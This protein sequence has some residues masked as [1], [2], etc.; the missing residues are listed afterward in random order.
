MAVTIDIGDPDDIHPR[1]K[2]EVGRRLALAAR[3]VAYGES[4]QASGPSFRAMTI[5]GAAVRITLD[6]AETGLMTR[7]PTLLGFEIAGAD[8]NWVAATAIIDGVT[9]VVRSP[10]VPEP[11]AVRYA[12][13]NSPQATLSNGVGLPAV[14]FRT[15]DWPRVDE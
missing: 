4:V 6:H 12:W 7:G 9:V 13:Q 8:R 1:N 14:P 5:E 10:E 3:S 15:D 11:V 2:H